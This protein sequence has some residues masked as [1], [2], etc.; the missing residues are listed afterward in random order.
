MEKSDKLEVVGGARREICIY[1]VVEVGEQIL[2]DT[3]IRF[4][5]ISLDSKDYEKGKKSDARRSCWSGRGL[6]VEVDVI[7]RR[8]VFWERKKGRVTKCRNESRA[9]EWESKIEASKAL[10][11]VPKGIKQDVVKPNMGLGT[12]PVLTNTSVGLLNPVY[13]S[14][15]LFEVG[16]SSLAGEG[17]STQ[18]SLTVELETG[19]SARC[20]MSLLEADAL[21]YVSSSS[22]EPSL[23]SGVADGPFFVGTSSD[24]LMLSPGKADGPFYAGT[25]SD[26]L[27]VSQDKA[28]DPFSA[29][30]SSVEPSLLPGKA[31]DPF[32]IGTSSDEL[33]LSPG[34]SDKVFSRSS[35]ECFL[36]NFFLSLSRAGLVVLGDNEGDEGG[37]DSFMPT[38]GLEFEQ[39]SLAELPTKA[40][41][42][43]PGVSALV[44]EELNFSNTGL[45]GEDSSPIPLLSITPFGLPL[46]VEL[47]CGNEAVECVNILDTSRWV[48]NRL[49]GFSKLVGLRL[50]RHEKLCIA[51]LQK[52]EKETEAAK[53]MNRKVTLSRKVVIY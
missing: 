18:I 50:N 5:S 25:S 31:D 2:A 11:W 36:S 9:A 40:L 20:A 7:G 47:N 52:I 38:A 8:R 51:L 29:G 3:R 53:A 37:L 48:K 46:T 16:E 41:C 43:V 12:S 10:K 39:P 6:V 34:K 15:S 26:E 27:T 19:V 45:G 13:S 14:P 1:E 17:G 49:P 21:F 28:D 32:S 42:V 35:V 23:P 33:T 22:D 30:I 44:E 4:P 24:E